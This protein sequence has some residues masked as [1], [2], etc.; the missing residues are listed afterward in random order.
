[1]GMVQQLNHHCGQHDGNN[2]GRGKSHV[3]T[4]ISISAGHV[5]QR[6]HKK[7]RQRRTR[8]Q[9]HIY[10]L[11]IYIW[12]WNK[13]TECGAPAKV[14]LAGSS[15]LLNQP[16]YRRDVKDKETEA[17]SLIRILFTTNASDQNWI[18]F[19]TECKQKRK[20]YVNQKHDATSRWCWI[21]ESD[22]ALCNRIMDGV[23]WWWKQERLWDCGQQFFRAEEPCWKT[24]K[25]GGPCCCKPW[26][27]HWKGCNPP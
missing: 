10:Q 22:I 8:C 21:H 12:T 20:H 9:L 26:P 27:L 5:K 6:Q 18:W 24:F 3:S 13:T 14:P 17:F 1:M 19:K 25:G 2:S 15:L 7:S 23:E 4:I 11:H 16:Q